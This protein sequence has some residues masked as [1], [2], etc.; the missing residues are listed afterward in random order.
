MTKVLEYSL[1]DE[2]QHNFN[3]FC[4]HIKCEIY[5]VHTVVN[6]SGVSINISI[7][8]ISSNIFKFEYLYGIKDSVLVGQ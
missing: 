5:F 4:N 6:L 1:P 2:V 3:K 7:I 8:L